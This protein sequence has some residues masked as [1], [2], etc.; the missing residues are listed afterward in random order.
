VAPGLIGCLLLKRQAGGEL[1]GGVIVET[2]TLARATG[3]NT[4]YSKHLEALWVH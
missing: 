1:L 2:E 4:A 3:G